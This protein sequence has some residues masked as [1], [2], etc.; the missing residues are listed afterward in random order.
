MIVVERATE[1]DYADIC[2]IDAAHMGNES[3]CDYLAK[4]IMARH[5]IVA[6]EVGQALGFGVI[7]SFFGNPFIELLIVHP[8]HR[9]RGVGTAI[10]RYAEKTCPSSKLFTSTNQSNVPM[11]KLCEKLGFIRSGYVENLDEGDPELIYFK[12]LW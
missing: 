11:Q 5:C 8:A 7:G 2:A 6:R 12:R 4:T 3:R 9:Q 1:D 10:I